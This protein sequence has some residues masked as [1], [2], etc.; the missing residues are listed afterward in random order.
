MQGAGA[1]MACHRAP[2]LGHVH[3]QVAAALPGHDL[4]HRGLM[5][6]GPRGRPLWRCGGRCGRRRPSGWARA[7]APTCPPPGA[8]WLSKPIATKR[9]QKPSLGQRP[10]CGGNLAW[11]AQARVAMR[12]EAAPNHEP[13]LR[14]ILAPPPTPPNRQRPDTSLPMPPSLLSEVASLATTP[15][16]ANR[17]TVLR[18]AMLAGESRGG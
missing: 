1:V 18:K 4:D 11:R 12:W 9:A 17:G 3:I 7:P 15:F 2:L 16:W 6:P 10:T 13:S 8:P 14:L 5:R